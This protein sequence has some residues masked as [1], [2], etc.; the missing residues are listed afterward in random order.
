MTVQYPQTEAL[1]F[2]PAFSPVA[3]IPPGLTQV[4][5]GGQNAVS[6]Q[7]QIVGVGDLA[8]QAV[9]VK[10][11]LEAGL[12]AGGCTWSDVVRVQ[13]VLKAD[14]DPRAA[15]VVFGPSLRGRSAAPLVGVS[16]VAA[17]AHPDFLL[18]VGLEAVR[19]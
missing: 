5:V 8:A 6:P 13:V 18:E 11:N 1:F 14:Q 15:F 12:A 9:Q 19:P 7:G 4:W 3:V 2:N 17:L 10:A 16:L